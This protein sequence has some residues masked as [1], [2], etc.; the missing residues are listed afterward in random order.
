MIL[1]RGASLQ[2]AAGIGRVLVTHELL[3][4][5]TGPREKPTR[6]RRRNTTRARAK[7][8]PIQTP[9]IRSHREVIEPT[10]TPIAGTRNLRGDARMEATPTANTRNSRRSTTP[11][12]TATRSQRGRREGTARKNGPGVTAAAAVAAVRATSHPPSTK[13]PSLSTTLPLQNIDELPPLTLML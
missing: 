2:A 9:G 3:L 8:R 13:S 4:L 12:K 6:K 1:D 10:A 5:L 11:M 7:A